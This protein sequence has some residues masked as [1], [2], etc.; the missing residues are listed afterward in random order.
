M[1]FLA[2]WLVRAGADNASERQSKLAAW[3]A[4]L[5]KREEVADD[6]R[7][8]LK[9]LQDAERQVHSSDALVCTTTSGMAALGKR[10]S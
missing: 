5:E 10:D 2:L 1:T 9:D 6:V 7:E 8:R 3:Q 4:G